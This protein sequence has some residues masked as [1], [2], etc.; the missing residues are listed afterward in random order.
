VPAFHL[1]RWISSN[2][3]FVS[4]WFSDVSRFG[5]QGCCPDLMCEWRLFEAMMVTRSLLWER[6]SRL[7]STRTHGLLDK[8]EPKRMN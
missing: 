6:V 4:A 1:G 5:V 3:V 7:F 8:F 2:C